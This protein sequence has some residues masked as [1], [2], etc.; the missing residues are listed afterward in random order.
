MLLKSLVPVLVLF[1]QLR[2]FS[3]FVMWRWFIWITFQ[4][5]VQITLKGG[6]WT[7]AGRLARKASSHLSDRQVLLSKYWLRANSKWVSKNNCPPALGSSMPHFCDTSVARSLKGM[8]KTSVLKGRSREAL[9]GLQSRSW[10]Q[11]DAVFHPAFPWGLRT[12]QELG[13]TRGTDTWR[14]FS[15]AS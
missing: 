13:R 7:W 12:C 11:M 15:L 14:S 9:V 6:P 8:Q 2:E 4:R 5:S 10:V 1:S 3:Y